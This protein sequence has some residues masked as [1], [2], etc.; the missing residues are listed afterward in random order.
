MKD[1]KKIQLFNQDGEAYFFDAE[2]F[3]AKKIHAPHTTYKLGCE[4]CESKERC[5][6]IFLGFC[7]ACVA[8]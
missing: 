1:T 3:E 7:Q 2:T 8:K 4:T 5:T 6:T